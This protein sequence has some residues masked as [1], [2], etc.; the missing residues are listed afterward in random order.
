MKFRKITSLV[1]APILTMCFLFSCGG[2]TPK[3]QNIVARIKKEDITKTE[4]DEYYSGLKNGFISQYGDNYKESEDFK[5]VYLDLIEQYVEQKALV[6]YAEDESLVNDGSI[7]EKVDEEFE[8]MRSVFG[9]DEAFETAIINSRFKD[10]QDYKSKLKIS[11][12]IEELVNRETNNLKIS[13]SEIKKYYDDNKSKFVKG[14]G[15][16]VYHIFVA[17]EDT[18][19]TVLSKIDD[20]EDF[21]KL[22]KTYSQDGSAS[23]DGYLGY[24][25]FDNSQLVKDFMDEVKNMKEGEIRGPVKT[26]FGYHI[27]KV[28]NVNSE[29]WTQDL[30]RVSKNIED[31]LKSDKINE[32][33]DSLFTKVKEKYDVKIYRE[34]I[35]G[36]KE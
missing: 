34:N 2:G 1:L 33:I 4:V 28:E 23:V 30:D 31:M 11:L 13:S 24:Q 10:E 32:T 5:N 6:K 7:Q 19:N 17:D 15:A 8:N 29:E 26:Q 20:G 9:S 14:A 22:A 36:K 21:G 25:E 27:I 18:A 16:D 35:T 3:D 12:I